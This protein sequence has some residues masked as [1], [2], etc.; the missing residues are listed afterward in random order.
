MSSL[1]SEEK[2]NSPAGEAWHALSFDWD[3]HHYSSSLTNAGT[4]ALFDCSDLNKDGQACYFLR[5]TKCSQPPLTR[6]QVTEG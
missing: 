3:E 5:R 1:S 4:T 6:T 2:T